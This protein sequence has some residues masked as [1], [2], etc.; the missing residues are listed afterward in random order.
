MLRRLRIVA[1]VFFGVL[2]IAVIALWVRSYWYVDFWERDTPTEWQITSASGLFQIQSRNR[3]LPGAIVLPWHHESYP[4]DVSATG[5]TRPWTPRLPK[6][7]RSFLRTVATVPYWTA[8]TIFAALAIAPI[9]SL[10]TRPKFRFT[11]RTLLIATTLVAIV[12]GAGVW[13]TS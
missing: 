6:F 8:A 1:S 3:P 7:T 4:V 5:K 13:A 11:T 12:L 9:L 10:I 2:T